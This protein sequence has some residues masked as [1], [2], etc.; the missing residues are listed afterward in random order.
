MSGDASP[1]I[2]LGED[3]ADIRAAVRALCADFG[4]EY[5]R[6][7]E[8]ESAYPTAFVHALTEAGYLGALIPEAYGGSGLPLRAASVI[9]TEIHAAGCNAGACHAPPL[10][11]RS[12]YAAL[13][14]SPRQPECRTYTVHL[15]SAPSVRLRH[16]SPRRSASGG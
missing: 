10:A 13:R 5:W 14:L 7:L 6:G 1:A 11:A 9:L 15:G 16:R 4:G 3:H 8:A 12:G 2:A